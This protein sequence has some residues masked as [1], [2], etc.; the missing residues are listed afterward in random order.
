MLVLYLL[1]LFSEFRVEEYLICP[2]FEKLC[3]KINITSQT[4]R[5]W[6]KELGKEL[7]RPE[8]LQQKYLILKTEIK[9]VIKKLDE[10]ENDPKI[11][12]EAEQFQKKIGSISIN[13]LLKQFNI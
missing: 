11:L 9:L 13:S 2:N 7:K 5:V 12:E 3:G 10:I 6:F 8:V 1:V 4:A